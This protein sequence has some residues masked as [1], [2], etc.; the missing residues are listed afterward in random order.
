MEHI[1]GILLHVLN[2]KWWMYFVKVPLVV[3]DWF[4]RILPQVLALAANSRFGFTAYCLISSVDAFY[5]LNIYL[6]KSVGRSI[7]VFV[8]LMQCEL[9]FSDDGIILMYGWS[10]LN[11]PLLHATRCILYH[12]ILITAKAGRLIM[13]WAFVYS[14]IL[15]KGP[16]TV[17]NIMNV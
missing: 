13:W 9:W 11:W 5:V 10:T 7:Y 1:F 14:L 15:G 6:E 3:M 17:G 8:N 2:F 4:D 12:F 16:F